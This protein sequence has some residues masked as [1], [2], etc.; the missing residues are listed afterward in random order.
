MSAPHGRLRV[1]PL[2]AGWTLVGS[3]AL[4]WVTVTTYAQGRL[5]IPGV[6]GD[7]QITALVGLIA[8]LMVH[9]G[10]GRWSPCLLGLGATLMAL[11]ALV[12]LDEVVGRIS[13]TYT[14][15]G[16]AIGLYVTLVAAVMLVG[17]GWWMALAYRKVGR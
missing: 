12:S 15:P 1:L 2:I 17:S 16:A 13:G 5:S 8:A 3:A 9:S 11:Y 14:A 6:Y 10:R 4:P 7:G